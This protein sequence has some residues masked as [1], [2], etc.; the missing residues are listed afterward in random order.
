MATLDVTQVGELIFKHGAKAVLLVWVLM[1]QVQIG[2]I[3]EDY[4]D[5]MNDRII[6]SHRNN[7]N[8]VPSVAVLPE[9]L[10]VK[11]WAKE[12]KRS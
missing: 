9:Q 4:K 11:R 7:S 2:E 10:K 6:D 3:R 12:Q 8:S 5:C 1:L